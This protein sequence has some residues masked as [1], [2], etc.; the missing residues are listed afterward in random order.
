MYDNK[1]IGDII[2]PVSLLKEGENAFKGITI[3]KNNDECSITPNEN[4][5][6]FTNVIMR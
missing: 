1:N 2:I 3:I 4:K 5:L 6:T